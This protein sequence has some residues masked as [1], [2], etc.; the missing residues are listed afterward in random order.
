[1]I[2]NA[3][4]IRAIIWALSVAISTLALNSAVYASSM[5]SGKKFY[6]QHCAGCHGADGKGRGPTVPDLTRH[7]RLFKSDLELKKIIK[8]GRGSMRGFRGQFEN[9][10]SKLNHLLLYLRTLR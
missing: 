7:G 4:R 5:N 2:V 8:E 1:M 9:D 6:A 3:R 10:E